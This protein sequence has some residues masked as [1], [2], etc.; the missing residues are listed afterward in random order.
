VPVV[1]GGR[2]VSFFG[3]FAILLLFWSPLAMVCS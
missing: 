1:S 2:L 3:F